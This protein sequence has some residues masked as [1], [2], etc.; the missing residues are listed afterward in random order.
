MSSSIFNK[1]INIGKEHYRGVKN[2]QKI[3]LSHSLSQDYYLSDSR[4]NTK[5]PLPVDLMLVEFKST[6]TYF[7]LP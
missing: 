6:Y 2:K 5:L 3:K 1:I 4:K 7:I